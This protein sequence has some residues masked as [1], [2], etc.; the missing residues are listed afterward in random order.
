MTEP[1]AD[2]P[3]C[4]LLSDDLI[5]TSRVT[6]TARDLGLNAR[7]ARSM[8][9]LLEYAGR[10]RPHCV[11]IDLSNPGLNVPELLRGLQEACSPMPRVGGVRLPRRRRDPARLA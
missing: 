10:Q 1:A 11:L 5:F 8:D 2:L 7:S 6:G 3:L 9:L 4:L